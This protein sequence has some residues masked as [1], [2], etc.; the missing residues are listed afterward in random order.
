MGRVGKDGAH[1]FFPSYPHPCPTPLQKV[2]LSSGLEP[3]LDLPL[4]WELPLQLTL[5]LSSAIL[6]QGLEKKVLALSPLGLDPMFNLWAQPQGRL[7]LGAL[8]G[9]EPGCS[10]SSVY[11]EGAA[12]GWGR[13]GGEERGK[14][15]RKEKKGTRGIGLGGEGTVGPNPAPFLL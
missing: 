8:P 3:G 11:R 14:D 13:L 1:S 15:I 4:A 10:S 9:K 7:F 12:K 5:N 2:V 6:S